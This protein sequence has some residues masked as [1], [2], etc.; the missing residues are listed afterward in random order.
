MLDHCTIRQMA[1]FFGLLGSILGPAALCNGDKA[2]NN[3]WKISVS[4]NRNNQKDWEL[5]VVIEY[6]GN[7][8][9]ELPNDAIPWKWPSTMTLCAS[10]VGEF[11]SVPFSPKMPINSRPVGHVKVKPKQVLKGK[12]LLKDVFDR[13][14]LRLQ[15]QPA[16]VFWSY[17]SQS[18]DRVGGWLEISHVDNPKENKSA[19]SDEKLKVKV[20]E[21]KEKDKNW[22]LQIV[23]D[24]QGNTDVE[25]MKYKLP[26]MWPQAMTIC[27]VPA[28]GLIT[29]SLP[30]VLAVGDPPWTS[31]KIKPGDVLRGDITPL[32]YFDDTSEEFRRS[33]III[34]W[35][36]QVKSSNRV[37]GWF[38]HQAS[39][40]KNPP[41]QTPD[42]S[43]ARGEKGDVTDNDSM[44]KK[45]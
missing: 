37:G 22:R 9:V 39:G 8:T 38:E 35:S 5:D 17:K 21:K 42:K 13:W 10:S 36:Y 32:T 40:S 7:K 34:Y 23:I 31:I 15:K 33:S 18:S 3:D 4:A 24:N 44:G 11:W 19:A 12:I 2:E 43:S 1:M 28:N 29:K 30:N 25:L 6:R 20:S 14:N 45:L 27:A 26:W 16:V 41:S